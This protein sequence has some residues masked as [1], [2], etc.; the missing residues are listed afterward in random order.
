MQHVKWII[1]LFLSLYVEQAQKKKKIWHSYDQLYTCTTFDDVWNF[2]S[3]S[4]VALLIN[5]S[6][7]C[8]EHHLWVL[9]MWFV[10]K[11]KLGFE[12]LIAMYQDIV[13]LDAVLCCY[14]LYDQLNLRCTEIY[15]F[16]NCCEIWQTLVAK[17]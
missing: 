3:Q 9:Y 8:G 6:L 16:F 14:R 11:V 10:R 7:V 4:T 13:L 5:W 1:L 12:V 17:Y 15:K 2:K